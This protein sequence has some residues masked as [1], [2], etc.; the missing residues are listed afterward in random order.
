M[1]AEKRRNAD[2][3]SD[4]DSSRRVQIDEKPHTQQFEQETS[5]SSSEDEPL[6]AVHNPNRAVQKMKKV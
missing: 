3:D 2:K 6:F 1:E 4:E 5:E